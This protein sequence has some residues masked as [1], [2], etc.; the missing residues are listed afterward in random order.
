MLRCTHLVIPA[1]AA[2]LPLLFL[3]NRHRRSHPILRMLVM[4]LLLSVSV[5]VTVLAMLLFQYNKGT[6]SIS[7]IIIICTCLSFALINSL[8]K[9]CIFY[10]EAPAD[11]KDRE[12]FE[13]IMG[14]NHNFICVLNNNR[15]TLFF[16]LFVFFLTVK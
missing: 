16:S 5:L 10:G 11:P 1:T 15:S 9:Y 4:L 7:S 2:I 6:V 3:S 12:Q 14:D 8:N 13:N